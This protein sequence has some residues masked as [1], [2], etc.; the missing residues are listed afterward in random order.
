MASVTDHSAENVISALASAA[1]GSG[2]DDSK[3]MAVLSGLF[4]NSA[5]AY[6]GNIELDVRFV[7]NRTGEVIFAK[8]FGGSQRGADSAAAL[9]GACKVAA[10]NFL[11]ELQTINPFSARVADI[12]GENIYIDQGLASGIKRGE[13][14]I[15][16]RET[17]PIIVNGKVIG[18]K[19][20]AICTA[21]V[22]E[23][24]ME[25]AV[26]RAE[27][28]NYFVKKGDIVKRG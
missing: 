26:C 27:G 22:I 24:N 15:I 28:I 13:V 1:T 4:G 12:H 19:Q 7:D 17:D 10:E 21:T 11:R 25:Y 2:D 23:V 6:T 16:A 14:L 18:M 20:T 8:S 3:A 5:N 9:N